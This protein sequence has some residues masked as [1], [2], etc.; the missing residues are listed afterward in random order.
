MQEVV[1]C[2]ADQLPPGTTRKFMLV[3]GGRDEE[4]L[5]VNHGGA[6]Y[7]WINRCQHVPMTMDWVDNRFLSEDKRFIVCATHGACFL[8]DTGECVEGPPF[9]KRLEPVAITVRDGQ[10]VASPAA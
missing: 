2:A 10:I 3:I 6:F 5:V 1:V 4:C 7:G 9:G 8:P